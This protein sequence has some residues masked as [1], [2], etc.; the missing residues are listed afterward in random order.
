M[1]EC[2]DGV[3]LWYPMVTPGQND[4]AITDMEEPNDAAMWYD[5]AIVGPE[6]VRLL[7]LVGG[8]PNCCCG[9]VC[10]DGMLRPDVVV[11]FSVSSCKNRDTGQACAPT[12]I[13]TATSPGST[14]NASSRGNKSPTSS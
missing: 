5:D 9:G 4:G 10:L 2:D 3:G 13:L 8:V 11:S 1:M 12:P 14:N 6:L 7:L